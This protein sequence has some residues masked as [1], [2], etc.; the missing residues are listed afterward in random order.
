M[1][2]TIS[3]VPIGQKKCKP[4]LLE[5]MVF[6]P[7]AGFKFEVVVERAC[8]PTADPVM[9]LVFDLYKQIEDKMVQVVHVS[10]SAKTPV[11][12]QAIQGMADGGI[13]SAQAEAITTTV[14]PAAK[15][16]VGKK[17]VAKKDVDAITQAMSGAVSLSV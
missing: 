17:K 13:K 10:Y 12:A 6:S 5:V 15:K 2:S 11:E 8:T 3:I 1:A 4:F 9:K 16:V 14:F 7:E